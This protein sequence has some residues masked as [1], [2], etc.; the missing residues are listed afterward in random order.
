MPL[1]DD[2]NFNWATVGQQTYN[3]NNYSSDPNNPG[4][5][6]DWTTVG[7]KSGSSGSTTD[8]LDSG[9]ARR[10]ISGV[11]QGGDFASAASDTTFTFAQQTTP[12]AAQVANNDWRVRVSLAPSSKI[13]YNDPTLN[14][15]SLIYPLKGSAGV[16]WPYTPAVT[17]IH[18]AVYTSAHPTHSL[19][20]AHFYNNS[21]VSDIQVSGDFT[22]QS[23][24]DGQYLMAAIYFFRACTKMFF[25]QGANVGNPPPM[26]FL[27]GYGS[28]YFP[29]VPCVVTNFSHTMGN[30]IDYMEIP[31][32]VRSFSN[33]FNSG[34]AG[35]VTVNRSSQT[36]VNG[37]ITGSEVLGKTTFFGGPELQ[38]PVT[39][40]R[41][42]TRLPTVSTVAV[43]LRPIYSRKNLHSRFDLNAFADGKLLQDPNSGYGGF[44]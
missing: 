42:S 5:G 3:P 32:G 6:F 40:L 25:G 11:P 41:A 26:V 37:S 34:Q 14:Q 7:T 22:V 1:V 18:N 27:D 15:D 21:E 2:T 36:D 20:P 29:H 19:Y 39:E 43:T 33:S 16:I 30:D 23:I 12:G 35:D 10:F 24:A 17:V 31:C 13:L 4:G 44:L 9:N 8:L 28:H 38:Q